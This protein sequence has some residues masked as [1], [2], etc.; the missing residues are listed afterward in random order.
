MSPAHAFR[1]PPVPASCVVWRL[2]PASLARLSPAWE[3][4]RWPGPAGWPLPGR[5]R[6]DHQVRIPLAHLVDHGGGF[7]QVMPAADAGYV[8]GFE[9]VR[10]IGHVADHHW[11]RSARLADEHRDRAGRV[12]GGGQQDE[13]AVPEQ[14][15][16]RPEWCKAG[17]AGGFW[18]DLLPAQA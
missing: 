7:P 2:V 10:V 17:V 8:A 15:M 18:R 13:A 3:P 11:R 9:Q 12:P 1:A 6:A 14:V 16:T 5:E 4:G